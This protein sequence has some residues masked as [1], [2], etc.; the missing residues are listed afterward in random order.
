M[1]AFQSR[2]VVVIGAGAVG[3]TYCYVLMQTGL[4]NEIVLI[5]VDQQKAE[6]EVMDL[7][8]GLAFVP[9]VLIRT[10]AYPDCADANL[11]V[12]TAGAKQRPGQSRLD[13]VRKNTE[14]VSGICDEIAEYCH[15]SVLIVVTNP[16]D[17]LTYVAI[18]KLGWR[19]GR[20]MGSGTVLDT[21]RFRYML[22]EL[23]GL[24]PRS[25]HAYVFGEHGDTEFA[26]W[27]MAHIGGVRVRDYCMA[28]GRCEHDVE[29]R[30]IEE[31][32]RSSAY[33][34]IDYKGATYW[35]IGL[36]LRRISEAILRN[37][38]SVLTV[39]T[40]L[41][42]EYGIRDICLSVP[43][44]VGTEGISSI[45]QAPLSEKEQE[46]LVAS[47]ETL[48]ETLAQAYAAAGVANE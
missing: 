17:I 41:T 16:V 42:G 47:A 39:S 19:R 44:V 13:L 12:L 35:A 31:A 15:E 43:C 20:V 30:K 14:I 10:G 6:G 36:A 24:D 40:L 21:S 34:I 25:I 38:N 23:C 33:H 9:P 45:L 3:A 28:C 46:A 37:E 32:V 11:I 18:R 1:Q 29:H 7:C 4:A 5:D 48:K 8:H 22:S 27:S 26:A 2:K